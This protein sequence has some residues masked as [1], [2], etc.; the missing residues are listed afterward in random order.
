MTRDEVTGLLSK[1]VPLRERVLWT[2][3]YETAARAD[4]LL[5]LDIPD[6]D[7]ANRCSR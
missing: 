4:K 7:T 6:L 2:M 5:L 3:L 1:D